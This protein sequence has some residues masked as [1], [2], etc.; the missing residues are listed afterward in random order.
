MIKRFYPTIGVK[1]GTIVEIVHRGVTRVPTVVLG[2][3]LI[4]TRLP[5]LQYGAHSLMAIIDSEQDIQIENRDYEIKIDPGNILTIQNVPLTSIPM[6]IDIFD[7][8]GRRVIRWPNKDVLPPNESLHLSLYEVIIF[9][10]CRYK[11]NYG[12]TCDCSCIS[13][14][15]YLYYFPS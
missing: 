11:E 13:D 1:R 10:S 6:E 2:G 9:C 7:I 12:L 5:R 4:P 14:C 3:D 8:S 15:N